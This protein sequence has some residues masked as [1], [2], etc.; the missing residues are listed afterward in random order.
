M[1][2]EPPVALCHDVV[3][4]FRSGSG[5]V[6][7]L[8][9][10]TAA[11]PRGAITTVVGPS[12]SGKSSLLRVLAGMDLPTSGSVVVAGRSIER[13][14]PRARR[15]LRRRDLGYVFQRP[16]DNFVPHLTVAQHVARI[17]HDRDV[18]AILEALGIRHRA[19]HVPA[20]LSGGEQQRAA[21]AQ[22]IA[23][24][25]G[26][27][28]A[29]EPTAEL[30]GASARGI[31]EAIRELR[32][33]GVSFIL[34]THDPAVTR[35]ADVV[36]R[37]DHGE[38]ADPMRPPADRPTVVDPN[39]GSAPIGMIRLRVRDLV[40]TY[41][42][43]GDV[44]H[45]VDDVSF[46]AAE[47]ELVGLVGRSGSGKTTLLSLIAG[48]ERADRGTVE[49]PGGSA[50]GQP[51]WREVAI[52]PQNLGLME[53][54]DIRENVSC[55]AKLER[56]LDDHTD[57]VDGLLEYLGL[58]AVARRRPSETSV[59]EQQRAAVARALVLRPEILLVDEPTCHQDR[60]WTETVLTAIRE[61]CDA[62]TT[63]IMATHDE[64]TRRFV[65]RTL[66]MHDG[67]LAP[68]TR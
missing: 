7:A 21:F 37:L 22:A 15:L 50:D 44:V 43:G 36:V 31:L 20:Q 56:L 13:A 24:G 28:V 52:V 10:V 6:P 30:D 26:I 4:T 62:G 54:L 35:I 39:R 40:K 48:W 33:R 61:T 14:S 17:A 63:C 55:P 2:S 23:S 18:D 60:G 68:N 41:G 57:R 25:A 32:A 16:S 49:R 34:A 27:V 8:R 66:V 67:R 11:F 29:D 3:R 46:E 59:G 53:E 42:L 45:A 65:D 9:G 1:R 58:T 47:G 19:D 51:P 12:G 5:K 64:T 38:V